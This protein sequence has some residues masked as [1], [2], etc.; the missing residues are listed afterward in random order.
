MKTKFLSFLVLAITFIGCKDKESA[1]PAD[2]TDGIYAQIET[3]KGEILVQLEYEKTPVT[4]ANFITLAEGKNK[5]V[6]EQYRD[7]PFYNNLKW[8]RVIANF[9]IQGG[10]P[11][12]TGAGDTG[13]KF[14][15]EIT[16]LAHDKPGI[17]SMANS[18]PGTNSSQ[19][20]ITHVPTPW[21]DGKHTAFGHTIKGQEVVDKIVQDDLIQSVKI[22][23]VGEKAKKFDAVKTFDDYF[24]ADV[25][26]RKKKMDEYAEWR[27][28]ATKL[29]SGL[30]YVIVSKG[31]GEKPKA[32]DPVAMNYTG[33]LENGTL[34]DS[35]QEAVV[36]E[37]DLFNKDR[38]E[39]G[40]Y[41]PVA[42]P[43]GQKMIAGFTEGLNQMRIGDK[44]ILFIPSALGYPNGTPNGIIPPGSNLIFEVEL[45]KAP[46][47]K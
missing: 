42:F 10:D 16:D 11:A 3:A 32:K 43:Y 38:K 5:Y 30:E 27:K 33:F 37:F 31:S 19:F 15:D 6:L 34:F 4:V 41:E 36:K 14:K 24:K 1:A 12:G 44:A 20:F 18:G 40:G 23:R 2:L 46:S 17:I 39:G 8:H 9:M 45:L 26:K 25:A 22:I 35:N 47:G 21:L 13:Y 28:K 29:P 7:K